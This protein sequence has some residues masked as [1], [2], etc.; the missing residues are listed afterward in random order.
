VRLKCFK[1]ENELAVPADRQTSEWHVRLAPQTT[2]Q[3]HLEDT[4]LLY[5]ALYGFKSSVLELYGK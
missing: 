5:F 3:H 4:I 2:L 1:K